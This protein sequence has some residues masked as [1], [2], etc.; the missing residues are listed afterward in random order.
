[1]ASCFDQSGF[2]PGTPWADLLSKQNL[3]AITGKDLRKLHVVEVL[4]PAACKRRIGKRQLMQHLTNLLR[5]K[6]MQ[7][8]LQQKAIRKRLLSKRPIHNKKLI[9]SKNQIPRKKGQQRKRRILHRKKGKDKSDLFTYN[10][11]VM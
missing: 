1:M 9:H 4:M 11:K 10:E 8:L 2:A 3:L 7:S 5:R 6:A